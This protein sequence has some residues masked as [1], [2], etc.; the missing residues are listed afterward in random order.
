VE[1]K[2]AINLCMAFVIATK[3]YLRE[4]YSYDT[5]DMA[6]LIFHLKKYYNPLYGAKEEPLVPNNQTK[7]DDEHAKEELIQMPFSNS[8]SNSKKRKRGKKTAEEVPVAPIYRPFKLMAYDCPTPTN[9]PLEILCYLLSYVNHVAN[10]KLGENFCINTLNAS[11][12]LSIKLIQ[13]RICGSES[14]ELEIRN[15]E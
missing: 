9:I 4:E 3:H 2:S 12:V 1:K 6:D 7:D 14:G 11:K 5:G 8:E 15:R 10:N 13:G